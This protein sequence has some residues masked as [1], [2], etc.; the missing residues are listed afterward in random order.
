MISCT[1]CNTS[2]LN[3]IS[4][5]VLLYFLSSKVTLRV[6][7]DIETLESFLCSEAYAQI[8]D[9]S[10]FRAEFN[11]IRDVQKILIAE[12]AFMTAHFDGL[13]LRFGPVESVKLFTDLL[14]MRPGK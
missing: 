12:E 5:Y 9:P 14:A 7:A 2:N 4:L 8:V 11:S 6:L 13:I 1:G 3:L 10:I